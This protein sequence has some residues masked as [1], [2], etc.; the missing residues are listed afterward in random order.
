MKIILTELGPNGAE[1]EERLF[2][3]SE[4]RI[5]RDPAECHISFENTQHPMVSRRHAMIRHDAG[6]WYVGDLNSSFGT[7]LNGRRVTAPERLQAGNVIQFGTDGPSIKVVWYEVL[8]DPMPLGEIAQPVAVAPPAAQSPVSHAASPPVQPPRKQNAPA[9][10]RFADLPDRSPI[11]ITANELSVGRETSCD[12][13]FD[14]ARVMVSRRHATLKL[15]D[16]KI[17]VE[18]KGSFNGTYVNEQRI[19]APTPLFHGDQV[20]FGIGGPVIMID[21]PSRQAKGD[22]GTAAQRSVALSNS[23]ANFDVG[24]DRSKTMVARIDKPTPSATAQSSQPELMMTLTFG[25]KKELGIGR[26]PDNDIRLDGLQISS[27]HA[28]LL[29]QGAD[30]VIDDLNSTNG[31]FVNGIRISRQS[32]TPD[33]HVLIGSFE[34]RI[35]GGGNI[36]IF[37]TR[38]KTRID[39]VNLTKDVRVKGSTLR[40]LDGISITIRPNEFVG[41]LGPS[42]AGKSTLMDALN[43]VRPPDSGTVLIN[44]RDLYRDLAS[45]KQSIGYV[46]QDDIIH[47]ELTVYRTLYYV[48]KLRLSRDVSSAEIDQTISEVLDVTGLTDRRD[49]AVSQLSGGQRKRVSIAVELITKPSMIFLDEP[50]S[51]LDPATEEKIMRLFRTIA[52]SGRT[53]VLTTHAM[54]NVKLFD[55]IAVLMRGRLVYFG[56]PDGAL[57]FTGAANF[58]ELFDKLEEPVKRSVRTNGESARAQAA[59]AASDDWKRRYLSS[60]EHRQ[61]VAEPQ[62][63][64]GSVAQ[65]SATKRIRLGIFGAIRQWATLSRRYFEVLL[66]D[67]LNLFILFAQA[68][69]IALLTYFVVDRTRPR[70]FIY[71]VPAIVSIWFGTSVAAREIIREKAVYAR[72]RMV[73]LGILPYLAS[74]FTVLGCIVAM[75]CVLLF[76]P[77]KFFDLVGLDPMPGDLFGIPQFWTMLLTAAVGIALGL[78]ISAIVKTGEMATSLVPLVLIPQILFSG[79]VGVPTGIS[80]PLSLLVPAAWSFDTMKRFSTLDTLEPEGAEPGDSTNGL[81]LYKQIETDNEKILTNARKDLEDYQSSI[82]K[83]LKQYDDARNAGLSPTLQKPDEL[84]AVPNA[85]KL[86]ADLSTYVT[87]LHPWMNEVLNQLVLMLMFGSLAIM[88]LILLRLKDIR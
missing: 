72:E 69:L 2:E 1:G 35:D 21:S 41:L 86:P 83:K 68:P 5:G 61:Y 4:I 78:F 28:R 26:G 40:L 81:G 70:D 14:A 58:K 36:G 39:A 7:Y 13:T 19:A 37:D 12:I 32:I 8:V 76:V 11:E 23:A 18:D 80:K 82:E 24:P 34:L 73:N 49:V 59:D 15:V 54:E 63:K 52:D 75:Q 77:L 45:L 10:I 6:H 57:K 66:K 74:K 60:N 56:T 29:R 79:I 38:S 55:K 22:S 53:V 46:P 20:R 84:P 30:I 88:T 71:F 43:G 87:F 50:T 31:V 27:K 65:G 16:E 3:Q 33:D 47:R 48:A 9:I 67:K 42:G 25:D 64:I 62:S 17:V 51:G 44:E 85:K